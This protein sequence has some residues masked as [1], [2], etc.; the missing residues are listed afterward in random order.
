MGAFLTPFAVRE[1]EKRQ[2]SDRRTRDNPPGAPLA[3]PSLT[4]TESSL[5]RRRVMLVLSRKPGQKV[6]INGGIT[7]TVVR[8]DRGRI[9][10]AVEAPSHVRV[11]RA[12]IVPQGPAPA[13]D[14]AVGPRKPRVK[15]SR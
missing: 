15:K 10:L 8:V 14:P 11:V 4:T 2:D 6:A 13:S 12:E 5:S 3:L 1:S 9:R 7:I